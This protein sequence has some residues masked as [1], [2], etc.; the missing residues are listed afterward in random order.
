M[1]APPNRNGADAASVRLKQNVTIY[2]FPAELINMFCSV[3]LGQS[4]LRLNFSVCTFHL[5]KKHVDAY[6]KVVHID[7]LSLRKLMF[8]DTLCRTLIDEFRNRKSKTQICSKCYAVTNFIK[9]LFGTFPTTC[10]H[11]AST[12]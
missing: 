5:R 8:E 6:S 3:G 2:K 9:L 4:M 7:M 1:R 11:V 10:E 12:L